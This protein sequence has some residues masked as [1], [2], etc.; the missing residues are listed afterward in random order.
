MK[1]CTQCGSRVKQEIPHGDDRLRDICTQCGFIHY[2]NP[3]MVVGCIPVWEEKIL[4]VKRSI[5]PR[6]GKW[7][8]PAGYLENGESVAEGAARETREEANARVSS[9][10]PFALFNMPQINQI[11]F[12]FLSS[13]E[14]TDFGAGHESL[15]ARLYRE[16]EIP[17]E[18]IAFK[19]IKRTMEL[20]FENRSAGGEYPFHMEDIYFDRSV[21]ERS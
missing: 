10:K 15:D 3:K 18:K 20:F 11:Y 16:E 14:N 19:V 17:W 13:L 7:T 21:K 9:L 1:Y 6:Y 4:L 12:M 8:L 5:E 2:H